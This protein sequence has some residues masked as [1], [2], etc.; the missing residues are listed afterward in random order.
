MTWCFH[1]LDRSVSAM[2]RQRHESQRQ[3]MTGNVILH[4]TG[5]SAVGF[6]GCKVQEEKNCEG[7]AFR[8]ARTVIW[9]SVNLLP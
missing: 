7:R 3:K 1:H 4:T 5:L 2:K 8:F 9:A 6:R